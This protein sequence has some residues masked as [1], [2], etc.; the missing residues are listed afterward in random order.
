MDVQELKQRA[1]AE[2]DRRK[3]TLL[4][5]S[6]AI[7]AKPELASPTTRSPSRSWM[8]AVFECSEKRGVSMPR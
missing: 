5:V 2:I 3:D 1:C 7:H 6:R 4:R 8:R